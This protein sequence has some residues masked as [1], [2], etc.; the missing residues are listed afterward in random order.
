MPERAPRILLRKRA[1][2][3]TTS[4]RN[5]NG[6][7][8]TFDTYTLVDVTANGRRLGTLSTDLKPVTNRMAGLESAEY[9][10]PVWRIVGMDWMEYDKLTYAIQEIVRLHGILGRIDTDLVDEENTQKKWRMLAENNQ[11]NKAEN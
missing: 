3:V 1:N 4:Y 7:W 5:A 10:K 2:G 6:E 11:R 9:S 8:A